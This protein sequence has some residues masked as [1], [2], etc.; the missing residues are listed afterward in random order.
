MSQVSRAYRSTLVALA[1]LALVACGRKADKAPAPARS[2][3]ASASSVFKLAA[4]VASGLPGAAERVS[5]AV[6]PENLPVYTGPTGG[7]RGVVTATGEQAPVAK[8]HLEKIKDPCPEGREMYGRLF[9]EGMMR[10]LADVLVAVT[11]YKAYLPEKE[12]KRVVSA[13]GCAFSTRT[14]A[15]TYGQTLEVVSKDREAYV[16]N[17]LGSNQKIQL[18]A[19]PRGQGS[20]LYPPDIGH[21]LLT[22][23]IKVFM[24]ADVYVLKYSTHDVT[25]LDGRYEITGIPPGKVMLN[26]FLPST[27]VVVDRAIDIKAGEVV[28]VPLEIAFSKAAYEHQKHEAAATASAMAAA[29]GS[30][31]PAPS[32]PPGR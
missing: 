22:D 5:K 4:P 9:R 12:P 28:E 1:A 18:L 32:V 26:A 8:A 6:N 24:L 19:L 21:Y 3:V 29:S 27:G 10:S 16:P 15:L 17:L 23:D 30:T 7:V 13:R 31:A 14:I 2:G 20:V 11:G 25:N